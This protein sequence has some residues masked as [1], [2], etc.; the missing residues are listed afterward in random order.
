[1]KRRLHLSFGERGVRN[2][3]ASE[4]AFYIDMRTRELIAAGVPPERARAEATAAFG[5]VAAIE[6]ACRDERRRD[7]RQRAWRERFASVAGD[8]RYAART[9]GRAPGFTAAALLTLA[10]GIGAN[11]AIFSMVNGVLLRRLPYANADRL[12]VLQQPVA[13]LG[14]GD[15]GFSP[16]EVADFRDGVPRARVDEYHSMSFDL[17]GHGEP[18]HV[19]TGVVSADFFRL[20]GVKP[21]LGRTFAD[22]EDHDGAAP[23]LVL[24][25]QF[26]V[27][28]LGADSSIIGQTFTMND[29]QHVVIGVLPP[30]PPYPDRNDVWMPISSCPFRSSPRVKST[31]TARMVSMV[32]LLPDDVSPA[33]A[34][35]QFALVEHRL[36]AAYPAAYHGVTD[37]SITAT[38]VHASMTDSARPAF[39]VLLG[40]A[41]LVLLV[42]CINVAHLTLAR[43]LRRQRE[44]AIRVALGAGR[45]RLLRQL[46]TES[47][48]LSVAGGAL[49]LVVAR[50]GMGA[51]RRF[52]SQFTVRADGIVLDWRVMAFALGVAVIAGVIFGVLP[53]FS[54][55]D[56]V[57]SRLRD[58]AS[59]AGVARTRLRGALVVG[60]VALAF[61]VLVGAGLALRSF[62]RLM[63]TAPGYDPQNVVTARLVLNFTKYKTQ[64]DTRAFADALLSRLQAAPGVTAAAVANQ[65]PASSSQ[66]Q[67]TSLFAIRGRPAPDSLHQPRAEVNVVS[68][69]YFRTVG[70]PIVAGRGFTAADRDTANAPLMLSASAARR[71]FP[72]ENAVGRQLSFDHGDHWL[73]VVGVAGDVRQFGPAV[74]VPEQVYVPF[75]STG[76]SD[77]RVL[78]RE[79][80][81][82]ALGARLLD[83]V[84]H[85]ID[86]QQPVIEIE[87]LEDARRDVLASP[88]QIA[89]LLSGFAALA[90][91]IAA[92]GLGGVVAYSVGQR[93][94]EFGIRMALGAE[95]G[96]ILRLVLGQGVRLVVVGVAIG[97]GGSLAFGAGMTKLLHDVPRTDPITYTAVAA[98]FIVVAVLACLIPA[99]RATAIDPASA[100][101]A[102]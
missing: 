96:S 58:G 43:Q 102:S 62:A 2:D 25:Y 47:L 61:A 46:V 24:S 28:Q 8:V 20:L 11:S 40:I 87:T 18:R 71:Y 32:A 52:A 75:A 6:D 51:L 30:L 93:T 37:A 41:G 67:N 14:I 38:P 85:S 48:L 99:R 68:A 78:V 4:L 55:G 83:Q 9:L 50:V 10:L 66:P 70:V 60:E 12:V 69:D 92:A 44:L 82:A 98:L 59:T 63:T 88:R 54:G 16:L 22:G 42:A 31:R 29:R 33:D 19:Q 74:D 3:V 26:W 89:V 101:R 35:R 86:A 79:T 100:F 17:L 56:D 95:R 81:R 7:V 13:S 23:V 72:R 80:N 45:R 5:N 77:V 91:V 1:M 76:T 64:H 84:V 97:I 73:T 57:V 36:H 94:S 21:M 34:Q 15:I 27:D 65:F 49:G 53:M 90:L 39:L